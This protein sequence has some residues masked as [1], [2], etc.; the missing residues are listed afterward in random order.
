VGSLNDYFRA[1][2]DAAA[3]ETGDRLAGPLAPGDNGKPP[4][5]GI[6]AKGIDATVMLGQLVAFAAD[7]DWDVDL[8]TEELIYPPEDALPGGDGPWVTRLSDRARDTL[9]DID[10]TR[11]RDLAHRCAGIEEFFGRA[12]PSDL[13]PLIASLAGLARRARAAEEHLYSWASL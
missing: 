12:K 11:T 13:E 6:D 7:A 8:V 4:F 10:D 5:D 1:A 2:D 3:A 9:S